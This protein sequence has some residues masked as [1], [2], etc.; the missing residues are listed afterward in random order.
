VIG[1]ASSVVLVWLAW[2]H[3]VDATY[4]WCAML[5]LA[6]SSRT[7]LAVIDLLLQIP[8]ALTRYVLSSCQ[9]HGPERSERYLEAVRQGRALVSGGNDWLSRLDQHAL[10]EPPWFMRLSALTALG[11]L[12]LIAALWLC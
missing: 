4:A 6:S 7:W 2:N 5:A 11:Y 12:P 3:R 9:S 1:W 8:H 10:N